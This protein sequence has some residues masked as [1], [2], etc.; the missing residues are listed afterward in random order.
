MKKLLLSLLIVT[1][2]FTVL[3]PICFAEDINFKDQVKKEDGSLFEKIIAEC[4]A[5]I[6]QTIYELSTGLDV[7]FKSYDGLIFNHGLDNGNLAPFSMNLWET[8]MKWYRIFSI[9]A[10]ALI[11]CAV[12]ILSYKI[13]IAGTNI[14]KKNDA[15]ESLMRLCFGGVAIALAPLFIRFLLFINNSFIRILKVIPSSLDD[16]IGSDMFGTIETGNAIT[17]AIVI[18]MF[19]YLFIKINIKFIIRQFTL[20]IFT[21]FTPFAAGLW[22][23]N[24]NASAASI[25]A[26]QIIMNI[27]MQFIYAFLFLVYQTFLPITTGWAASLIWAMML[28]PIADA[29]LN[30]FQNLTSRIAGLDNEMMSNRVTGA[31]AMLGFGIGAITEQFKTP[32]Q[33]TNGENSSNSGLKGL[34]NRAKTLVNPTMKLGDEKDYNGNVNPIRNV[35][36]KANISNDTKQYNL[37]KVA[38]T[39]GKAMGTGIKA[40]KAYLNMGASMVEGDFSRYHNTRNKQSEL[41]DNYNNT[42]YMNRLNENR[43]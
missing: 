41:K 18:A 10:G 3:S 43:R 40:T 9:F 26:G 29:L 1:T 39:A 16:Y 2:L 21:I 12:V 31:G 22:I 20:I 27:F 37:T 38:N 4:I 36:P 19:I 30:C 14:S 6:A 33:K 24:K 28:L 13:S 11:L 5:G 25:W 23:I 7:G 32:T 15:K 35:E 17:T 42:E 34:F 8:T